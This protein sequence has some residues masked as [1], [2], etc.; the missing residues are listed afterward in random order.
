M[1][2]SAAVRAGVQLE[3]ALRIALAAGVREDEIRTLTDHVLVQVR[4][5][6]AAS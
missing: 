6:R 3:I 1:S 2:D 4:E 5:R